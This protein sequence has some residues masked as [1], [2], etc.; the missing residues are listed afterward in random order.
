MNRHR[1]SSYDFNRGSPK[2]SLF[3]QLLYIIGNDDSA[4]EIPIEDKVKY[5]DDMATLDAVNIKDKLVE[6]DCWQ[7]VPS[8]IAT[9]VRF[10]P[11]ETFKSQ[12]VN[13]SISFW[14][15]DNNMKIDKDKSKYMVLSKSKETFSTRLTIDSQPVERV[16]AMNH[17]GVWLSEDLTWNKHVTEICKRCY[18]RIKMLTKFKF[19]GVPTEDLINIYCLYIRSLTEYCLTAFHS[20]LTLQLS[21]K[22]EA[23]KKTCLKVII[24]VMYVDYDSALEMCGLQSLN[25][26]REHRSL[27]FSIKCTK[28]QTNQEMFPLNQTTDIH[29]IRNREIF[30]VN[31]ANTETSPK[32][33]L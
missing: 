4:E 11:V 24:D 31:K 12:R 1:S 20:S 2:G 14:T 10:L 15:K 9:G 26:R 7:H 6:Y 32:E 5:I 28:H 19:F 16:N 18:P 23:I 3:G 25:M 33:A 29:D 17:L 13:D 30:H 27:Q 21:N 22:I 8:D